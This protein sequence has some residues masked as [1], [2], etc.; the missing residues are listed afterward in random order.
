MANSKPPPGPSGHWLWGNIGELQSD[1][2]S[3]L[4]RIPEQ[5]G[6]I[7]SLRFALYRVLLLSHPRL[8]E[9]VLISDHKKFQKPPRFRRVV[10]RVFG[11]GLFANDGPS[12]SANRRIVQAAVDQISLERYADVIVET[13]DRVV[14]GWRRD[15]APNLE[16][17]MVELAVAVRTRTTLGLERRD[18]FELIVTAIRTFME[19][20]SRSMRNPLSPPLWIPTPQNRRVRSA[21][22]RWWRTIA[23]AM[24]RG[25][26]GPQQQD[27]LLAK[28]ASQTG[29]DGRAA[30]SP[31]ALRDEVA[32]WIMTGTETLANTL[33]WTWHL[34]STHPIAR[35]KLF[36]ELDST[37]GASRP[38]YAD[39]GRLKYTSAVLLESMRLYPQAYIIGRKSI[40]PFALDDFRFPAGTTVVLEPMVYRARPALVSSPAAVRA[41]ALVGE[42]ARASQ[43]CLLSVWRRAAVL[44]WE[45][46][47]DVGDALDIGNTGTA[48]WFSTGVS[49][50]GAPAA[51][52]N[53]PPR[54]GAAADLHD[55][56][57]G[58]AP[59]LGERSPY[60]WAD[61]NKEGRRIKARL[62]AI[63]RRRA[64]LMKEFGE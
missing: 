59:A 56:G 53:A 60:L 57:Q 18:S 36:Q 2:L 8:V 28:L 61:L 17:A 35:E 30:M 63:E 25:A 12:W 11:A 14:A 13:T 42:S 47:R 33:C 39:I 24:E 31:R 49:R 54:S 15:T 46:D 6:E 43:V 26:S 32:T 19:Y 51:V 16:S 41:R 38:T 21:M 1:I 5:Y 3:M 7:V 20:F 22:S 58:K 23:D 10:R 48:L 50:R 34:L 64:V 9:Q 29:A 52:A 37:I 44:C 27:S 55:E 45:V 62:K 4:E 40:A